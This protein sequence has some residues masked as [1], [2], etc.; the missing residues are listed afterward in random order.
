MSEQY[1]VPQGLR[2]WGS[3]GGQGDLS[4]Q[5]SKPSSPSEDG[6]FM[7]LCQACS[8]CRRGSR[9]STGPLP[10]A[11]AKEGARLCAVGADMQSMQEDFPSIEMCSADARCSSSGG[12]LHASEAAMSDAPQDAV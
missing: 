3:C 12:G 4:G 1:K 11:E 10:K 6:W 2:L 9:G 5:S 8:L 7:V